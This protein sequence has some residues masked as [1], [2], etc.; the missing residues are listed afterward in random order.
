MIGDSFVSILMATNHSSSINWPQ[1]YVSVG[2]LCA[3][4][5]S[6]YLSQGWPRS[7]SPYGVSSY[8]GHDVLNKLTPRPTCIKDD[9][10]EIVHNWMGIAINCTKHH[11]N[12]LSK[13]T[14]LV[15]WNLRISLH[16]HDICSH[17]LVKLDS[18]IIFALEV[19]H[20]NAD[21][22]AWYN[23]H[24]FNVVNKN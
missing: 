14:A 15:K 11:S 3:Q 17:Q 20:W 9:C 7:L 24:N 1:F 23:G 19:K 21:R 18:L 2:V 8:I 5:T 12:V 6:H 4:V 13:R 16:F 22:P 10:K